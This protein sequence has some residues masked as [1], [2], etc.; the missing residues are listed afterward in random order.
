MSDTGN[1][2]T[3]ERL[4][5]LKKLWAQGLS[6]SQIGEALGVSR[7]AIAGKAHRM[8]LPKRPSP[9][10][11]PKAEKPKVEPVVEEQD[12]P[13]RLELRQLVWSRS[14]CCWPTGDPKKNGFVFC[15]D[16][17]VPGKPY[18]LPHCKEAYTTS[19]DAS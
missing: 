12:L 3:D 10:S 15:G 8:G 14:K 6:I 2:W 13:L 17:V 4:E 18:C 5:E 1:V 16:T 7:N 19:R 11:K 9:I